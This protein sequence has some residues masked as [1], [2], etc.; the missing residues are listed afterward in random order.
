MPLSSRSEARGA[1][2]AALLLVLGGG[3]LACGQ[4]SPVDPVRPGATVTIRGYG[5]GYEGGERPV[6]L[7]WARTGEAA[8]HASIDGNGDFTAEIVAPTAPGQHDLIVREGE[9]DPAPAS[10]T[11]PVVASQSAAL[12]PKLNH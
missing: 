1:L 8:G 2:A 11:V 7:V 5:Y 12:A 6:A 9:A 10:V 4:M 3:A